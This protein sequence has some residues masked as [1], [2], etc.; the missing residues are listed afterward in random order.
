[1]LHFLNFVHNCSAAIFTLNHLTNYIKAVI[2]YYILT[3]KEL[4]ALTAAKTA[5]FMHNIPAVMWSAPRNIL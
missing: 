4:Y 3:G 2:L 1:M 5:F